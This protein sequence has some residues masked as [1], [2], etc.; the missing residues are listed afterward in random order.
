MSYK[1]NNCFGLNFLNGFIDLIIII[2][3]FIYFLF[4]HYPTWDRSLE[5]IKIFLIIHYKSLFLIILSWYMIAHYI[6][7]YRLNEFTKLGD[8]L[9]RTILQVFYFSIILF[10]ISGI[11]NE[12]LYTSKETVFFCISIFIYCFIM[13]IVV[14]LIIR[15]RLNNGHY[16]MNA[17]IV[18]EKNNITSFLNVIQYNK[19]LIYVEYMFDFDKF[20]KDKYLKMLENPKLDIVYVSINSNI[21]QDLIDYIVYEAQ[22]R[23]KK[24]EF[25]SD[26]FQGFNHNLEIKYYDTFPALFFLKY[27]LDYYINQ[28]FKRTFDIL[29][30]ILVLSF[31]IPFVF[32]IIS[33]F[34]ILDSGMPILYKQKRKGLYG[35]S[36][37]CLKFRTM[38]PNKDNDLKATVRGDIRI[39]GIGKF[40]RKTSMDELPQFINV[41]K[42]EMSIVGPRPHMI[43]QDIHF[44][45]I[46]NKYTLRHYVK[47]GITGLA[48]I[49]GYRGEINCNHDME[50]RIRAD[51]FYVRNWS[52]F[53][54]I[55]IVFKTA[56]KM[57]IGDKNAI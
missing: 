53:M 57:F 5:G 19:N 31:L 39:T 3:L 37:L 55:V 12:S 25:I 10:S 44:S 48:Q 20:K 23:F 2:A 36:F 24:I 46:I 47:P 4:F 15:F 56:F 13:K 9:K 33:L 11:K 22:K 32:P 18:G 54:D 7:F 6:K 45:N 40:L 1:R 51:I 43:S 34:I 16:L 52:F 42:G 35:K 29:F 41:L 49:K 21:G 50:L 14:F 30:S 28:L 26:S 38:K 8:I 17:I 27:P